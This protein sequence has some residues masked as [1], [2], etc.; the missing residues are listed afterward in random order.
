MFIPS[1]EAKNHVFRFWNPKIVRKVWRKKRSHSKMAN[2]RQ[3]IFHMVI[4]LKI[5]FHL[6]TNPLLAA[7]GFF[8]FSLLSWYAFLLLN[9]KTSKSNFCVKLLSCKRNF[10]SQNFFG[11]LPQ[12]LHQ[13]WVPRYQFFEWLKLG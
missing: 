6:C 5:P 1:F 13:N 9:Q 10:V 8:F 11:P 7:M 3:K 12:E 4:Y 2:V